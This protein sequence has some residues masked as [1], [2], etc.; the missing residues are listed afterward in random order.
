MSSAVTQE[1]T[2]MQ[3]IHVKR[4][5]SSQ[6]TGYQGCIEPEDRSWI[7]FI[8]NAGAPA[9]WRRVEVR[10]TDGKTEHAYA[11]TEAAALA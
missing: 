3:N 10:D 8:D 11:P 4:Y 9:L 7:V 5:E 1:R 6:G 2:D